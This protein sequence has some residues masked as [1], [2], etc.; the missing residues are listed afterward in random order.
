MNT[1]MMDAD[2]IAEALHG[3]PTYQPPVIADEKTDSDNQW[4][5]YEFRVFVEY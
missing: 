2:D 4:L 3:V 5:F 1:D